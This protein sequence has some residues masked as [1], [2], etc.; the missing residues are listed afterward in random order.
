MPNKR[1]AGP[2]MSLEYSGLMS[3]LE[4]TSLCVKL[5]KL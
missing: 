5:S 2:L 1:S 3:Y 4:L